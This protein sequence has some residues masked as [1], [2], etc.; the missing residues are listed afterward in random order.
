MPLGART[1]LS[2]LDDL[3]TVEAQ[4][5]SL[6]KRVT[7]ATVLIVSYQSG[8]SGSGV[9]VSKEGLVLTAAHV[10]QGSKEVSIV[11]PDGTE[12]KG[13]VLGANYSRDV[14]MVQIEGKREWPFAEVGD[15]DSLEVGDFVVAMG[16]PKG[17]DPTRRPPVRFGRVM[18]KG[19]FGFV[20][21]D[22]TLTG[23]DSGGPL[24]DL[25]GRV[26]AVH[27]NIAP[28]RKV[29]NHA[30]ASGFKKDWERLKSGQSW[31]MLGAGELGE[32]NRP[33]MGLVLE[34]VEKTL[35]VSSV[36]EGSPAANAGLKT[37]DEF[38]TVD[39]KAVT[40]MKEYHAAIQDYVPGNT[41]ELKV[42]R[43]TEVLDKKVK[44]AKRLNFN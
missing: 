44:F 11:F 13:K 25:K 38:V 14:A 9:V 29:N 23:G 7:P 36:V 22:C 19:R 26:V 16:H 30:G 18:T 6:T 39:R 35:R 32:G 3:K 34:T 37:G 41:V 10:I 1:E 28:S 17:Y 33:V 8:G 24:F 15:S 42:R 31:G 27:S 40:S 4:V 12:T 5:E 21:T 43:G 20:T 2:S